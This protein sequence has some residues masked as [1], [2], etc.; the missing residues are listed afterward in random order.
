MLREAPHFFAMVACLFLM[1]CS[2]QKKE[3]A[4]T[5][6][7][8]VQGSGSLVQNEPVHAAPCETKVSPPKV[9]P[10]MSPIEGYARKMRP[11]HLKRKLMGVGPQEV[12]DT[13]PA[14]ET[15]Q[16]CKER[17][18]A[19]YEACVKEAKDDDAK[20][21]V[22]EKFRVWFKGR[23]GGAASPE[24]DAAPSP[25]QTQDHPTQGVPAL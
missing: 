5:S 14:H 10:P 18:K 9:P 1:G 24:K 11:G 20:L 19:R 2:D 17:I 23:C 3:E 25:K 7:A 22:C 12:P 21:A 13:T 8:Q 4:G 6:P 16:E 15:S